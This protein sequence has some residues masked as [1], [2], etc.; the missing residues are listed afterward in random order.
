M[1]RASMPL[2]TRIGALGALSLLVAAGLTASP[3]M[4]TP[5]HAAYG[6]CNTTSW[7]DVPTLGGKNDYK[8]PARSGNGISC[9]MGYREGASSAVEALQQAITICYPG[10]WAARKIHDS[11][12]IDGIY[13]N[14]TVEA[15]RW[16][17]INKL[18]LAGNADGVYGPQTR[19]KMRWP[20]YYDRGALLNSCTNPSTL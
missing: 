10:T 7:R 14:G 13:G 15:V 19:A 5:A 1:Q 17:Q 9:Y 3:A 2:R 11:D 20:H 6:P 8:I 16:L 4:T 18:N 12:G